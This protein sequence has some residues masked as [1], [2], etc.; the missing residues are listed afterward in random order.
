M[1]PTRRAA[2]VAAIGIA[3][4]LLAGCSQAP[5]SGSAQTKVIGFAQANGSDEWRTNQNRK[6]A[7]NC[8]PVAQ[9]FISDA[10]GDDAVQSSHV[11]EFVSRPSQRPAAHAEHGRRPDGSREA[12]HGQ[13]HPG[14]H[15]R[16]E[17]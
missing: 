9:T 11:D 8:N 6:V 13:G 4:A 14:D 17:R 10:L 1:A 3:V 15:A 16:P 5:G 7:E 12:R 2:G